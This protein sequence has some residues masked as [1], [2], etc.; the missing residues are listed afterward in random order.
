[1]TG[2]NN[3]INHAAAWAGYV[4]ESIIKT[5]FTK[6]VHNR[7][8]EHAAKINELISR[9]IFVFESL[10]FSPRN[11]HGQH[12]KGES[13][14]PR[15]HS[16]YQSVR[17]DLHIPLRQ[18][19]HLCHTILLLLLLNSSYKALFTNIVKLTALHKHLMTKTTLK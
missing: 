17:S 5:S 9:H 10:D 18:S 15:L 11:T 16:G 4:R 19:G 8:V 12:T 2:H 6:T 14:C 3:A 13:P 1:M 7:T